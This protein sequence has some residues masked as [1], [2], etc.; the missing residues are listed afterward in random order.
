MAFDIYQAVTDRITEMLDKGTVPWRHPIRS[1]GGGWPKNMESNKPYRGVN[2]FLLG[3]T[4]WVKGFGSAYWLTYRQA[5][6][7]GGNVKKGEKS[8]MVVFWKQYETTDKQTGDPKKV[9]VLRYYNV[10]NAEQCDGVKA[11][12][13]PSEPDQ[14]FEAIVEAEEIIA[15]YVGGP[16][17]EHGGNQAFYR[18]AADLVRTAE[19]GQFLTREFFYATM[20][21]ELAHSTGHQ[22]RLDR[23][24]G[25]VLPPFGSPDY[26]REELVAEMGSAF[27]CATAGISPPTIEQAAAYIAGWKKKLTN[28]PKL[29]VM[30]SGAGQRAA[31]WIQGYRPGHEPAA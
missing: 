22:K 29:I 17:I 14:P 18:P 16:K 19:P 12:D 7:K 28:D 21:H 15:G 31:D 2:V 30:A 27:L 26:S 8:S 11:P 1:S 4:S 24:L 5:A 9:P 3:M 23:N 25:L 20:F 13:A 10:F 6:E